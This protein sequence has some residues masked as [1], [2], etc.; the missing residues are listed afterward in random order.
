MSGY[1]SLAQLFSLQDDEKSAEFN[2]YLS[3]LRKFPLDSNAAAQEKGL[4]AVAVFVEN[5][6]P[7]I[8]SRIAS[9]IIS[10]IITKCLISPKVKTKEL[11]C[12]IV[13]M[14]IEV[15]KQ[16]VVVEELL[17]GTDNKS[18]KI[19]CGCICLL[20]ESLRLFGPRIIKT[21]TPD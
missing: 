1:E 2:K 6:S 18:P 5:A 12:D 21:Y 17:K 19:V 3:I 7:S 11:A 16:E 14:Y 13:L 10:G 20:K 8:S 15:E 4:S 9:E